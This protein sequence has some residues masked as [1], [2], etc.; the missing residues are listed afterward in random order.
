[1][2]AQ[3]SKSDGRMPNY[4]SRTDAQLVRAGLLDEMLGRK[5]C[6]IV[7]GLVG[8]DV[9]LKRRLLSSLDVL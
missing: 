6:S 8:L 1:M 3:L 4:R 2:D 7:S 9:D 5:G